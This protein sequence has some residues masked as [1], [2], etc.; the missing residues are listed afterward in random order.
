MCS[1]FLLPSDIVG[2]PVILFP[3]EILG[4]SSL[5]ASVRTNI[6]MG[7]QFF[8]FP[9]D[10]YFEV[11]PV[12]S[13][14]SDLSLLS[15][16]QEPGRHLSSQRVQYT[17]RLYQEERDGTPIKPSPSREIFVICNTSVV[18]CFYKLLKLPRFQY[19]HLQISTL[20]EVICKKTRQKRTEDITNYN[21]IVLFQ[22]LI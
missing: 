17:G 9:S 21:V 6:Y 19:L 13:F 20:T 14:P 16:V 3:S 1:K 22:I 2:V 11:F 8:L 4:F 5:P 7:V 10:T 18:N 15:P 12:F